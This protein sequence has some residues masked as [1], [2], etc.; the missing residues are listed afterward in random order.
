MNWNIKKI[1]Y[2]GLK[3]SGITIGSVLL[4]MFL[5]PLLFP[6][7][8]A[9]EVKLFANKKLNGELNFKEAN[10]SFFSHFPSLTLTLTDFSL[11]GSVPF[12]NQN[13]VKAQDV[14][15][16]V[17][18]KSLLF[19]SAVK[20]D[21]IYVSD[22]EMNILVDEKGQANYNVYV[23][24]KPTK[25]EKSG[26][27]SLRL[28]RIQIEN[29]HLIYNDKSANILINALGFNYL[30]KG[31]FD[32]AI[33]DL[34]TEAQIDSFDFA[35]GGE[36]YL[37]NKKVNAELI[38]QI[39]TNSL[40]F[41]FQQNNLIINQ[42]PIDF[43]GKLNFLK[44][45][46]DLDFKVESN[47]SEL[48]DF[49]TALPPQYVKWLEKTEI[50]GKTDLLLT[51]KGI[52][53]VEE[54]KKPDLAF[55]MN[56]RNGL[57]N[58]NQ[59]QNPASNL[60][61]QLDTKLPSLDVNQLLVKIT[62]LSFSMGKDYFNGVVETVGL[63]SPSIKATIKSDLDLKKLHSAL[64]IQNMDFS[65]KLIADVK[66]NGIYNKEKR[67]FPVTKGS[68]ILQK[69]S[70]KTQWYPNPISNIDLTA[71]VSNTSG[72]YK[73]LNVKITPA[74]FDFEGK[75]MYV[76]ASFENFDDVIYDVKAKG[77]IDLGRVY[78]VFSQED[79]NIEGFVRADLSLKGRQSDATR[80]IY[81]RLRNSGTLFLQ[82][83]ST[84][85]A[86]LPK[87]FVIKEGLFTFNQNSMS[88]KNFLASYGQS[89]FKM[90][91]QMQNAINFVMSDKAIL[92][93]EFKVE[94][95]Y[96]NVDEFMS[97][98]SI[99]SESD[100]SKNSSSSSSGVVVVPPNF[101]FSLLTN[102]R[103]V[104]FDGLSIN[105]LTSYLRMGKG[106]IQLKNMGFNLIGCSTKM[107]ASYKNIGTQKAVFDYKIT[108]NEFDVKKAYNEVKM[109]RDMAPAAKT[110]EG[111]VS[112]DYNVAGYLDKNMNPIY[113]SLKGGGVL[114]VK[115]VKMKGFK[116]FNAVSKT[117]EHEGI[118]NPDLSE[119]DI[120]TVVKN[121]IMTVE[122]F[123]FKV[124]G[125]RPRIAGQ[126]SLDGKLNL[127]MRLGL[128]P[129]GII[130]IP[131]K[132]TGTQDKPI[133]KIGKKSDDLEETEYNEST[134]DTIKKANP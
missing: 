131:L 32:K 111:I 101:D 134:G 33:F 125:F 26:E 73:D 30:G 29:T 92:K 62:P 28:D 54:N 67:L 112:L 66:A 74:S 44:S 99:G 95:N 60:M 106:E 11:K 58:Y 87:P 129:L 48:H 52:Y 9:E 17:N 89:D 47:D 15:F 12:Q 98:S 70:L 20:I 75:K 71:N 36:E 114:S 10:L 116:L 96:I 126:A 42:L 21:E 35:F 123:K 119:I 77:E 86:Y 68:F 23:S 63:K 115:K 18:I 8:I 107:N 65:G 110:A 22:A 7:K 122:Q 3:I 53:N 31:D 72:Q 51:L 16:G 46:Y 56:I 55:A 132:I 84:T 19:E 81:N 2:K 61:L 120:K 34:E 43:I 121:N 5:L 100:S 79:L 82:N 13:L 76:N 27:T 1:L 85:S 25:K 117:T 39:N 69:A 104:N 109:F 124:A 40:A 24:E 105:N 50:G 91:G 83:I 113:P 64:G 37:K 88:F 38:T 57:V 49:F 80:G 128:P 4:L 102:F 14:A 90:N 97:G 103:K 93:G 59:S 41:V 127:K 45:G 6:G 78:K 130:G 133:V 118:K 94:S 108:A